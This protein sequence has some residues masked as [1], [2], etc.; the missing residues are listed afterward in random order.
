MTICEL[1]RRQT[2]QNPNSKVS[3]FKQRKSHAGAKEKV[4]GCKCIGKDGFIHKSRRL[5]L[6]DVDK[7]LG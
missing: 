5:A 3:M 2:R 7:R 4:R 6:L 1:I